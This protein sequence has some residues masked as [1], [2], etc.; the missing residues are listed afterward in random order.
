MGSRFVF[1]SLGK[2]MARFQGEGTL[3]VEREPFTIFARMGAR[4]C[5]DDLT[6]DVGMGS[7]VQ[8]LLG[9]EATRET[10]SSSDNYL[11]W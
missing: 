2:M 3:P 7:R 5:R 11:N 4:M 6:R 10:I 9:A 1:L 8:D